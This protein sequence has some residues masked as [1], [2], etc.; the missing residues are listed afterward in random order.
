M[1]LVV[2]FAVKFVTANVNQSKLFVSDFDAG[3]VGCGV[4]FG[5]NLKAR[6]GG[7][8]RNEIDDR[9]EAAERLTVVWGGE[10][11]KT[12]MREVRVSSPGGYLGL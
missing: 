3:L 2:P 4:Q 7:S 8:G 1:D 11:G 5:M 9:L 12:P 10:F 6:L